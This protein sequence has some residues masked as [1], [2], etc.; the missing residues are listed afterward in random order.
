VKGIRRGWGR[1]MRKRLG[2]EGRTHK[3]NVTEKRT[4]ERGSEIN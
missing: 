2:R 4:R 1:E 3:R